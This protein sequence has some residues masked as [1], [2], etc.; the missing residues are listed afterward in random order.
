MA[1]LDDESAEHVAKTVNE[2]TWQGDDAL[3]HAQGVLSHTNGTDKVTVKGWYSSA[4]Y[5]VERVEF[6]DGT[7][8]DSATLTAQG[9][10][11]VGTAGAD[12]LTGVSGYS[13][14]IDGGAGKRACSPAAHSQTRC[15]AAPGTTPSAE[16]GVAT[17]STVATETMSS[18]AA[19]AP[20]VLR[21][22][23]GDDT[24][25]GS[26]SN[27]VDYYDSGVN[28]NGGFVAGTLGNTYEGGTG[29]DILRGT[30]VAD[31]YLFN[32]GDGSDSIYETAASGGQPTGQVDVLRF[33][34]GIAPSDIVVGR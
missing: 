8:W 33:G 23:A 11:V 4:N 7:A 14:T 24:L 5:Q 31:L 30:A 21:G 10:V 12:T 9:L 16:A 28:T 6:A 18:T 32:L 2:L 17:S 34:A 13:N 27:Y 20:D 3:H 22:G 25:G 1:S 15:R 19:R 26:P 29:N